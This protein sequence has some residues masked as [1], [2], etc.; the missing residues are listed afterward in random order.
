MRGHHKA[1]LGAHWQSTVCF[2]L[3]G[4]GPVG[5]EP[6]HT[7]LG[8]SSDLQKKG[9]MSVYQ[10]YVRESGMCKLETQE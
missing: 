1:C 9:I 2:L 4:A 6:D 3:K 8:S 7:L 5:L 10:T